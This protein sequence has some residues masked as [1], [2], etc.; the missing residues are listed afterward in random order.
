MAKISID[1]KDIKGSLS[2]I[3]YEISDCIERENNG[4][5][6]QI[7]FHNSGAIVTIYDTNTKKNTVGGEEEYLHAKNY[8]IRYID[9]YCEGKVEPLVEAEVDNVNS[10]R[11]SSDSEDKTARNSN[12]HSRE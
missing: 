6:W 8:K 1:I 10:T 12:E 5:N 7:K 11:G 9:E 3:G 2:Q 4:T